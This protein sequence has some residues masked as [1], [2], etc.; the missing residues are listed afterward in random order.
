MTEYDNGSY[1]VE[2]GK[3]KL[4][5]LA[6][7][8]MLDLFPQTYPLFCEHIQPGEFVACHSGGGSIYTLT[9]EEKIG[10]VI[11]LL[12]GLGVKPQE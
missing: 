11:Q 9:R 4:D 12:I 10:E 7:V 8:L 3:M 1:W 2:D 5:S 6:T